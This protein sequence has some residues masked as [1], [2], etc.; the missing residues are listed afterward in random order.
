MPP[1]RRLSSE[2]G[3]EL[4]RVGTKM[5]LPVELQRLIWADVTKNYYSRGSTKGYTCDYESGGMDLD[6]RTVLLYPI[7]ERMST[8]RQIRRSGRALKDGGVQANE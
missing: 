4:A 2:Q 3:Y 5:G 8:C 7:L 6:G 1:S